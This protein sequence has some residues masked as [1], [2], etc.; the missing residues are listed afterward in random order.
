MSI[1]RRN[2]IWIL[3]AIVV[4][5]VVH[6]GSVVLLPSYIMHRTLGAMAA[7]VGYNHANFGN[8]PTAK[9]RFVV[10]PS[11]DLLYNSCAYDLKAA[12]GALLVRAYDMPKTYW[13]VSAF[14][15]NTDNFYVKNDRQAKGGTIAFILAAPGMTLPQAKAPVVVAPSNRGLILVR[16]LIDNDAHFASIAAANRHFECT[17]YKG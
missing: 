13:S 15:D 3:L 10:R 1:L 14:A 8:R 17:P 11:P 5:I 6:V 7:R 12:G 2:W 16:T 9:S 4:A